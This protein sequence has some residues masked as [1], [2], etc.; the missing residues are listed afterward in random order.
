M[1]VAQG[2]SL[3]TWTAIDIG[4]AV[5]SGTPW[6]GKYPTRRRRVLIADFESGEYEIGRRVRLVKRGRDVSWLG[7]CSYPS[8]RMDDEAVWKQM[9]GMDDLGLVIVDSLA[10]GAPGVD[11]NDARVAMPLK[12]A[13]RFTEATGAGVLFIHHARKD[14]GDD[15]K[16]VRGSTALFADLDWGYRFLDVSEADGTRRMSMVCIKPCM[17]PKP[18]PVPIELSDAHGLRYVD[19]DERAP[20]PAKASDED[21]QAAILLALETQGPIPSKRKIREIVSA[22]TKRVDTELDALIKLHRV[23]ELSGK[24]YAVDDDQRR[25]DRVFRAARGTIFGSTA[26]LGKASYT[27]TRFVESLVRAGEIARSADGRLIVIDRSP[28][29]ASH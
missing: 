29:S 12:L 3:K 20:D 11:E 27:D 6:L 21:V 25:R 8:A 17:G 18:S 22:G 16:M 13:A 10:A 14:D 1:L 23:V 26:Q 4:C 2:S 24:G 5:A 19:E 9:A 28:S 15:R 7:S